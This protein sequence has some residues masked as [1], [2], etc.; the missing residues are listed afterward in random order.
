EDFDEIVGNLLD[1]AFK[2]A[3]SLVAIDARTDGRSIVITLNDD[4]PGISDDTIAKAFLPGV[5]MDETVPGDGFG[6]TIANELAQLYGGSIVLRNQDGKGLRQTIT[7]P[8]AAV[9]LSSVSA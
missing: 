9:G 8:K 2:W 3:G 4:G 1:N 5:R 6:L 7:L